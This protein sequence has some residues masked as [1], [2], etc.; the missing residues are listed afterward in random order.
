MSV[1]SIRYHGVRP[2]NVKPSYGEFD[3]VDFLMSFENRKYNGGSCR[4]IGKVKINYPEGVEP[5]TTKVSYDGPVGAHSFIDRVDTSSA[6]YGSIE[7]VSDYSRF[8]SAKAQSSLAKE[9]MFNSVYVC[10]NRVPDEVLSNLMLKGMVDYTKNTVTTFAG[11][12]GFVKDLDFSIKLDVAL[13]N[14][15]GDTKLPYAKTG[16]LKVSLTLAR[17]VAVLFG[18]S[19]IGTTI[20]Y[21]LSD[22]MLVFTTSPDNLQYSPQYSMRV[23]TGIKQ[24]V[25]SSFANISTK[26]PIVA[27]SMF[28]TF[29]LQDNE[30]SALQNGMKGEE[31]PNLKELQFI[32]NDALNQEF[33]YTIKSR[34]ETLYNYVKAVSKVVSSNNCSL[35]VLASNQGFGVGIS[36]GGAVDLSKS[37]LGMNILS[38][39]TNGNPYVA[40]LFFGGILSI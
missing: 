24:S 10:E 13:N 8:I 28:A 29:I 2:E 5:L 12:T 38:D 39:I 7:N 27:D 40:Y 20:N 18:D 21:Q 17:N 11:A 1:D 4:L 31:I 16:D 26:V 19:R 6:V 34:E 23:K 36:F 30:N 15:I 9:D 35:N 32:W 37:K 33:T 22:L 3:T 25:Q 14:L